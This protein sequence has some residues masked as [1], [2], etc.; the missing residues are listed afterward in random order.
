MTSPDPRELARAITLVLMPHL[1]MARKTVAE[2]ESRVLVKIGGAAGTDAAIVSLA[3]GGS[4]ASEI[5]RALGSSR[6][7]VARTVRDA[8]IE[9]GS[10]PWTQADEDRLREMYQRGASYTEM[11]AGLNRSYSAVSAQ[12]ERMR[13]SKGELAKRRGVTDREVDVVVALRELGLS[14]ADIGVLV[15]R[16]AQ[17]VQR[18]LWLRKKGKLRPRTH[19]VPP[20]EADLCESCGSPLSMSAG[21]IHA[22]RW[23]PRPWLCRTC[24]TEKGRKS[25]EAQARKIPHGARVIVLSAEQ[26]RALRD[27]RAAGDDWSSAVMLRADGSVFGEIA[28]ELGRSYAQVFRWC[29]AFATDPGAFIERRRAAIARRNKSK[30]LAAD[31]DEPS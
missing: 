20:S 12:V 10:R 15:N 26:R 5:A 21:S 7:K 23:R 22:R 8:G 24:G 30:R 28:H 6:N 9:I 18:I 16:A 11:A 19:F 25:R 13:L 29:T 1:A 31:G 14:F 2:D 17:G 27:L 4:D 3:M